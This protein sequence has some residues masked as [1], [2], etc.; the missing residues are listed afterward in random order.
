MTFLA[1]YISFFEGTSQKNLLEIQ[2]PDL[3][4]LVFI[5]L[6]NWILHQQIYITFHKFLELHLKSKIH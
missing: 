3:L 6:G 4:F 5:L 1:T 2:P